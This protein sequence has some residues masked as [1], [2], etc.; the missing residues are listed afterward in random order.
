MGAMGINTC[1]YTLTTLC[2]ERTRRTMIQLQD[3]R[4]MRNTT[5]STY[6]NRNQFANLLRAGTV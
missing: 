5:Y 4:I 6:S 2:N 3:C 1:T